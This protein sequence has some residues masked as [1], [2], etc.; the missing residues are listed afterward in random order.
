MVQSL[1]VAAITNNPEDVMRRVIPLFLL[2]VVVSTTSEAIVVRGDIQLL[3]SVIDE[4]DYPEVVPILGGRAVGTLIDDKWILTA[5]HVGQIVA[6]SSDSDRELTVNGLVR[7]VDQV[8]M[9]PSWNKERLGE[10][11][12]I[13]LALLRLD[14]PVDDAQVAPLYCGGAEKGKVITIFGWGRAGDGISTELVRD[15]LF[16]RGEN[17]ID[18]V[19]PRI[20]FDFDEP[21][22]PDATE[23][24]AVS[25]P[26]DSGGPAFI[27]IQG[28][29]YLVGV[30]S[31]QQ[32]E[33]SPGLY[34]VIENYERVS[35]HLD[36]INSVVRD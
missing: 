14:R 19:T 4:R 3:A 11:D 21:T 8:F 29:S 36:W 16:R 34:G 22:S 24:E 6:N 10:A 25:G 9:H 33:V 20:R 13:D 7:K 23:Y 2:V 32:D 30:S 5:A 35:R 17:M 18:E 15:R 26:G 31:F 27:D 1:T 12:V 28:I